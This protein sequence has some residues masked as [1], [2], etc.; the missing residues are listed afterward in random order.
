MN[1]NRPELEA[2]LEA[3][4]ASDEARRKLLRES[5]KRFWRAER[6]KQR[7]LKQLAELRRQRTER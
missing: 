3:L 4:R 1:N 6:E 7:L 2:A 5:R